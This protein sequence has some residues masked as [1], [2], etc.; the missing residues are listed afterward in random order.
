MMLLLGLGFM[1]V[2]WGWRDE[3]EVARGL[4][5]AARIPNLGQDVNTFFVLCTYIFASKLP[6]CLKETKFL[7]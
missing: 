6:R 4:K 3:W 7:M 1:G 2:L 5:K